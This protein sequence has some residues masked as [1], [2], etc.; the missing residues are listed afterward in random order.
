MAFCDLNFRFSLWSVW[1]Q[2]HFSLSTLCVFRY[3][4]N[5]GK[6][7]VPPGGDGLYYF[8]TYLRINAGKWGRFNIRLF[9]DILCTADGDAD[10]NTTDRAQATCSS[11]LQLN[12]GWVFVFQACL[13]HDSLDNLLFLIPEFQNLDFSLSNQP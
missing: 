10:S 1:I 2:Q 13:R 4:S 5:T 12:E 6:F 8:S 11:L 9:G 7:T 3:D